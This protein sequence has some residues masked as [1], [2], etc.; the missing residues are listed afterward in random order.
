MHEGLEAELRYRLADR[1]DVFEG[2]LARQYHPLHAES[3]HN[4]RAGGI[5]HR[6]LR[7]AMDLE[8]RIHPLNEPHDAEILHDGRIDA[9]VD[10]LTEIGERLPQFLGLDQHIEREVDPCATGVG[11]GA[12]LGELVQGELGALVAGVV[13]RRAEVDR[14]GAIGDRSTDRVECAGR[15]EEF[16]NGGARHSSNLTTVG[17]AGFPTGSRAAVGTE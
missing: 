6:H 16:R 13:H 17:T 11:D 10:A 1:P 4:A 15:G 9:A 8:L 5:V 14:V 12:C 2:V 3:L 7:R